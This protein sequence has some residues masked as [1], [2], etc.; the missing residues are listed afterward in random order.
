MSGDVGVGGRLLDVAVGAFCKAIESVSGCR[1]TVLIFHR[2]LEAPDPLNPS[3]PDAATFERLMRQL[4]RQ[5]NVVPLSTI[6]ESLENDKAPSR[7]VAITFDD[8]YADNA[9]I[10]APILERL[11]MNATFFIATGYLDGGVMWNDRIIEGVRAAS[12]DLLDLTDWQ[13]GR[14]P[15]GDPVTRVHALDRLLRDVKY[16]HPERREIVSSAIAERCGARPDTQIM[17]TSDQVRQLFNRGMTIGGHTET[18]PILARID[19]ARAEAEI[20]CGKRTLEAITGSGVEYFAYPNGVPGTDFHPGHALQ[21][22]AAGFRAA[23]T[24][25]VG[26]VRRDCNPFLIPRFTPWRR[27]PLGFGLQMARNFAVSKPS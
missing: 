2:V 23:V 8:G 20:V 12:G 22:N 19:D 1:S 11:G 24:T 25:A 27:D 16:L 7:A 15:L 21:V 6:V 4:Q 13:L 9:S 14:Y 3:T 5:F 17:M 10:A 18:H 26:S